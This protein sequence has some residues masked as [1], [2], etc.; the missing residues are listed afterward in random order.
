MGSN[1][2]GWSFLLTAK[3]RDAT[4]SLGHGGIFVSVTGSLHFSRRLVI[5]WRAGLKHSARDYASVMHCGHGV[6]SDFKVWSQGH[7][8]ISVETNCVPGLSCKYSA[9]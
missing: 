5:L 1:Y 9:S 4:R 6:N 3:T 8:R 2:K 7:S